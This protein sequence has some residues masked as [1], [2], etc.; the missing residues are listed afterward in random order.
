[1]AIPAAGSP[2]FIAVKAFQIDFLWL[3]RSGL[4]PNSV[5]KSISSARHERGPLKLTFPITTSTSLLQRF[6][7]HVP[8]RMTSASPINTGGVGLGIGLG[9]GLGFGLRLGL[10]LGMEIFAHHST[11]ASS[12]ACC[13]AVQKPRRSRSVCN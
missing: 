8:L 5:G 1:M 4:R 12:M 11:A 6:R 9:L 10:G 3:N 2:D 13:G 7:A